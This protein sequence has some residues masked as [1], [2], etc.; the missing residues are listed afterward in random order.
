MKLIEYLKGNGLQCLIDT[1]HL[2]AT[3][4][5]IYPELVCLCYDQVNTPKNEITNECRGIIINK[6]TFEIVCCPFT[7]F[8]DYSPKSKYTFYL[9]NFRYYEKIDGSLISMYFYNGAWNVSTKGTPNANGNVRGLELSYA[10]YFWQTWNEYKYELPNHVDYTY[11]FEFKFPSEFQF[12]TKC[13]KPSITLIGLRNIITLKEYPIEKIGQNWNIAAKKEADI[14]D[15]VNIAYDLNPLENEGFVLV[16]CMFNRLKLKSPAYD[17]LGLLKKESELYDFEKNRGI[18]HNNRK[19]LLRISKYIGKSHKEIK[20]FVNYLESKY[21]YDLAF[22]YKNINQ[23]K[24]ELH[25]ELDKELIAIQHLEGKDLGIFSKTH[26]YSDTLFLLKKIGNT[27]AFIRNL[28]EN[29]YVTMLK[30]HLHER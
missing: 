23:A 22:E 4:S 13:E 17:L 1:Y 14:N 15:L 21:C 25:W 18:R 16:D 19:L 7:R 3:Y 11:I 27:K 2:R 30:T 29:K 8:G 24:N 26:K 6:D 28:S 12:L 10:E 5:E 9:S 20:H